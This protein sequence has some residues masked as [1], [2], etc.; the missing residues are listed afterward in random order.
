MQTEL[1]RFF[2]MSPDLLVIGTLD[3]YALHVSASWERVLGWTVKDMKEKQVAEFI[4][5][6]DLAK[7]LAATERL[8]EAGTG[9][10]NFENRWRHKNDGWRWLMWTAAFSHEDGCLYAIARDVTE[11]RNMSARLLQSEQRLANAQKIANIGSWELDLSNSADI[12]S[13][14]LHWSDQVFRIFGYE[15]G[16][17]GV[18]TD[19]FF[20]AVHPEDREKV[21]AAV[22]KA[23]DTGSNYDIEHR[24][25]LPDGSQRIVR[26]LSYIERDETGKPKRMTGTVQDIT[27]QKKL[28]VQLMNA[29]RLESVGRLT[30]GI[31][32][33]FNNMLAAMYANIEQM[34]KFIAADHGAF[35][36]LKNIGATAK[37]AADLTSQLMA[38]SQQRILSPAVQN[39]NLL[40]SEATGILTRLIGEDIEMRVDLSP[41]ARPVLADSSQII[42]IILNLAINARDA[43][44]HGGR[45]LIET[46][47]IEVHDGFRVKVAPGVY[48]LLKVSDTGHG[49][50]ERT[51]GKI[52]DPFFTTKEPGRGTGLG[53]ATVY[54][55]V[56]QAGGEIIVDSEPGRGTSFEIY[57]PEAKSDLPNHTAAPVSA[58]PA[59]GDGRMV[60]LVEDEGDLQ[61]ILKESLE[62]R[63]FKVLTARDGNQG[64]KLI[65]AHAD[66]L[67][68]LITDIVLPGVSGLELIRKM[69][70]L[71]AK[72]KVICM[73]GYPSASGAPDVD[74]S[75][76][77]F[78]PKPFRVADLLEKIESLKSWS[79]GPTGRH[80]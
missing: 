23:V 79:P 36:F 24:I 21:R 2:D 55:I 6:D 78:M 50:D 4:H 11:F 31:A 66:Q 54:G 72:S 43:M 12:D 20:K 7:T 42:Q 62:D 71:G 26:E 15:P 76:V 35:R 57:L 33:D 73:S 64:I 53:L 25:V 74:L 5:P 39:V 38:F 19:N 34:E 51:M 49:M 9:M 75:G 46:S 41:A 59:R 44:P 3:G 16:E 65:E 10:M 45:L 30:G 8:V 56:H 77:C 69:N 40:V 68:V 63:G 1:K 37:R 47:S 32:H 29:Q 61:E 67:D 60:L 18:S 48:T 22:K 70:S 27:E 58:E 14:P 52:F 80:L 13:Y 28:L 17:I